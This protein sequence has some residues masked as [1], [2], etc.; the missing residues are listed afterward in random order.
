MASP[1]RV[2]TRRSFIKQAALAAGGAVLLAACEPKEVTKLVEKEVKVTKEVTTVVEKVVTATP[3]PA[4]EPFKF[5]YLRPVWMP[6]THEKGSAYE[7]EL[8]RR[9]NVEIES[10]TVPVID[11]EAKFPVMIAGGT[12]ADVMWHAGPSWGTAHDLIEQGAFLPLNE[13]LDKYPAVRDAIGETLWTLTRSPDGNNYFFPSPLAPYVPFPL[14][15]R[16]DLYDQLGLGMP[17]SLDEF[18]DQLRTIKGRLPDMIPLTLHQYTLWY[19]QNVGVA[20]GYPWGNWVPDESQPDDNPAKIV[21]G[22]ATKECRNF[23]AWVQSLRKEELI[24]PDWMISTGIDGINKYRAGSAVTMAGHWGVLLDDN[25]E[26][27]KTV[28]EGEI[29]YFPMLEGP[30]RPMGALTLSGFDRGF[31][32]SS[33]AS[34]KID[35]IF[36]FLNWRFTDGYEF[37]RYGVEGKTYTVSEDGTKLHIPDTEREKGWYW[38]DVEAFGFP[39]PTKDVWP[40]WS[41]VLAT[42]T[43]YGLE[44]KVKDIARMFVTAAQNAMPN[45]NHLTFSPT[46]AEKGNMLN[47]QYIL[48]AQDTICID[49]TAPMSTWDDAVAEWLRNGGEQII[50]EVNEIQTDKSPIKPPYELPTEWKALLL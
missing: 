38:P 24:D 47:Q 3:E 6:A 8:F 23:L 41:S 45:W 17:E 18:V 42:A 39:G 7:L 33:K 30:D 25:H 11:Y 43:K 29:S 16:V 20:H 49:P 40:E 22:L 28:P 13:Y 26:L 15:Y 14:S 9:A 2:L 27:R 12:Y 37:M 21:P 34:D 50:K 31:S 4:P 46:S 48:P 44:S 10:Q 19:F 32:I 36:Q 5:S 1:K 35:G